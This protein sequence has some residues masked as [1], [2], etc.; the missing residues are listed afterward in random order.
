MHKSPHRPILLVCTL[1]Q[2]STNL[3]SARRISGQVDTISVFSFGDNPLHAAT[4][5]DVAVSV[6]RVKA[7][8]LDL[9]RKDLVEMN[10]V[11]GSRLN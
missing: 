3:K 4:Y 7:D 1:R 8:S 2:V 11:S 6:E 10:L 9:A 5:L